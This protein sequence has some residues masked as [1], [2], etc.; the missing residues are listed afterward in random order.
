MTVDR[1][2]S[3]GHV[4]GR[5]RRHHRMCWPCVNSE[6]LRSAR[7]GR[8]RPR[9]VRGTGGKWCAQGVWMYELCRLKYLREFTRIY[10]FGG[11]DTKSQSWAWGGMRTRTQIYSKLTVG[12]TD[13][14]VYTSTVQNL[15]AQVAFS[16]RRDH[17]S[18]SLHLQNLA[19]SS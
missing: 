5:Q 2:F 4:D 16:P 15:Y 18:R 6:R 1:R 10:F 3:S 11:E 13:P 7:G 9:G 12:P 17:S 14:L 8:G 19:S